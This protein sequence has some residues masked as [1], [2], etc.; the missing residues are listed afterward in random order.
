MIDRGE[1]ALSHDH[2]PKMLRLDLILPSVRL[3]DKR[4]SQKSLFPAGSGSCFT[5]KCPILGVRLPNATSTGDILRLQLGNIDASRCSPAAFVLAAADC[6][7]PGADRAL[8]GICEVGFAVR[9]PNDHRARSKPKLP[10]PGT[11]KAAGTLG[12]PQE[13]LRI[14]GM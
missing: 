1:C 2:Q 11:R 5:T 4:R 8:D 7:Q 13:A 14:V 10:P 6:L 12:F 3:I 9:L